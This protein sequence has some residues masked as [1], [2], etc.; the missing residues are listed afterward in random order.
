MAGIG[1]KVDV[2]QARRGLAAI[3]RRAQDTRPL[4]DRLGQHEVTVTKLRFEKRGPGWPQ[5]N[6]YFAELKR[7][8]TG[9]NAPLTFRG[10]LA[11]SIYH[12]VRGPHSVRAGSN[13]PYAARQQW[14]GHGMRGPH[15]FNLY[16]EPEY[17]QGK[18]G[19]RMKRDDKGRLLGK[20]R[21]RQTP[22]AKKQLMRSLDITPRPFLKEPDEA[23]WNEKLALIERHLL[24]GPA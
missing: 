12:R 10:K 16:I 2:S 3:M 4:M 11:T 1:V 20:L 18:R 8:T 9:G 15:F 14:G 22:T 24:G 17:E 6:P 7:R 19:L 5:I 13:L 23:N 21:I